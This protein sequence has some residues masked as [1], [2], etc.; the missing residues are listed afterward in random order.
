MWNLPACAIFVT[1]TLP[2]GKKDWPSLSTKR[3]IL[4]GWCGPSVDPFTHYLVYKYT[5]DHWWSQMNYYGLVY[6]LSSTVLDLST[7]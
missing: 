5:R 1:F 3:L 7:P 6:S 2:P 4:L